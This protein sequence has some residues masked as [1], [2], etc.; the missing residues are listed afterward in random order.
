MNRLII[1]QLAKGKT[2]QKMAKLTGSYHQ[3][4]KKFVEVKEDF[5]IP[6]PQKVRDF[7]RLKRY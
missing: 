5:N 6:D 1:S 4:M 7:D 3:T 2:M